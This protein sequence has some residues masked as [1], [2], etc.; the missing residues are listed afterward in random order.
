MYMF[1]ID[2]YLC[3]YIYI[4]YI[5]VV[6]LI[7]LYC[8]IVSNW[9]IIYGRSV[10]TWSILIHVSNWPTL[11][12]CIQLLYIVSIYEFKL[13]CVNVSNLS[14]SFVSLHPTD[15]LGMLHKCFNWFVLCQCIQINLY[16]VNVFNWSILY[17]CIQL[18]YIVSLYLTGLY[19][20]ILSNWFTLWQHI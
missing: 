9:S 11:C 16:C 3:H 7:D 1:P 18:I 2:L 19:R 20:I 13:Y 6:L 5:V 8:V 4:I 14:V 12:Q 15:L 17:Q 10:S